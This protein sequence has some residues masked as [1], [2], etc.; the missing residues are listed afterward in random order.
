MR[1]LAPAFALAVLVGAG[2]LHAQQAPAA[3]CATTDAALPAEFAGWNTTQPVNA[4]TDPG[5]LVGSAL[6][7]GTGASA[8]LHPIEDVKFAVPP[9]K[10]SPNNPSGLGGLFLLNIDRTGTY[11]VAV[12]SAAWIDLVRGGAAVASTTHGHGPPCSSIRKVVDFQLTPGRYIVQVSSNTN[13]EVRIMVV[14]R[15]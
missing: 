1:A 5:A 10:T 12:G 2:Q 11:A 4:A 15:P 14:R 13:P 8:M 7:L 9:G 3:A 6:P